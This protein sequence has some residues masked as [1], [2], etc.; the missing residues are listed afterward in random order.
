[1]L[2]RKITSILLAAALVAA[3]WVP[4]FTARAEGELPTEVPKPSAVRIDW[5][6][7]EDTLT[8]CRVS[9]TKDETLKN[10]LTQDE[11][12]RKAAL[13]AAGYKEDRVFAQ[14]DWSIDSESNWHYNRY[15]DTDTGLAKDNAEDPGRRVLGDWAYVN[16]P[17]TGDDTDSTLI[18]R[19]GGDPNDENNTSWQGGGEGASYKGWKGILKT[20]QYEI[21]KVD[22]E[23]KIV[24]GNSETGDNSGETGNTDGSA[25]PGDNQQEPETFDRVRI[26]FSQH[27]IYVRVRYGIALTTEEGETK[28]VF[29]QWSDIALCGKE[30]SNIR[31]RIAEVFV[32]P[33]IRDAQY[34]G[35]QNDH[36][37]FVSFVIDATD[38]QMDA[39]DQLEQDGGFVE[40]IAEGRVAGDEEW[41]ELLGGQGVR[42]GE[43][44]W[45]ISMLDKPE[46][47]LGADTTIELRAVYYI[48]SD[49][50]YQSP[51][52]EV[53]T[54]V[55]NE[56]GTPA[57]PTPT[58]EDTPTP[59]APKRS[60]REL[61]EMLSGVKEEEK[62]ETCGLC[63]ICPVQPLGICLFVWIVVVLTLG[64]II[65]G[66]VRR[67]LD[68][69]LL[70][71]RKK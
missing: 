57:T 59:S 39:Q 44:E 26:D 27:T 48:Y 15:W 32:A 7:G 64:L 14:I 5:L 67:S 49:A 21:V 34:I 51:E 30:A 4:A 33:K 55:L 70:P 50:E 40:I 38:E 36:G 54:V 56:A 63:G 58:P 29:S 2:V 52:S 31:Y 42:N 46:R 24:D 71:A 12:T 47:P 9:Y 20:S 45:D 65:V 37:P 3:L 25:E 1:M 19:I 17:V 11:E 60:S 28:Y 6:N 16:A 41:T 62:K 23:G 69:K 10:W 18:F 53:L 35:M 68:N 13:E 8:T 22:A 61:E 43:S 66:L